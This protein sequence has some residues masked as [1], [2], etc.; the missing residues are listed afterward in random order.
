MNSTSQGQIR[1]NGLI[2]THIDVRHALVDG[3][4]CGDWQ[5][6]IEDPVIGWLTL[7][8]NGNLWDHDLPQF[9]LEVGTPEGWR[10]VTVAQLLALLESTGVIVRETF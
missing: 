2:V 5:I 3:V 4:P 10:R 9:V 8:D 7:D 1:V 6:A